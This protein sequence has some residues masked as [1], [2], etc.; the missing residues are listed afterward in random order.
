MTAIDHDNPYPSARAPVFGRSAVAT[1][2][3]LAS[4]AGMA[5]LMRGGNA[6]DAIVASAMALTVVEP[7]GNGI[8][9]DAFAIV[10]D[11]ER[12]HGLNSS[13]RAPAAWTPERFAGRT[14]MPVH[15]WESVSVPGAVASWAALSRRFGRLSLAEVAA[16][17]IRFAREG[18]AVT[19]I[20]ARLWARAGEQ[21]GAQP[22]FAECF[23]PG[24][25]APR[26]GELFRCEAQARTLEDI[27][28]TGGESFYR[29]DLARAMANDARRHGAAMTLEDLAEH[30]ADWVDTLSMPYAGAVLHELPPNGQGIATLIGLGLLDALDLGAANAYAHGVDDPHTVHLAIEATKLAMV[31]LHRYVGDPDTMD[32]GARQLLDPG[33]LASRARLID[34]ARAGDP[35][36]GTPGP[37]GTVCLAAGDS[38]GMMVSFIQSNYMGFGSGVVVPG[39]GI[40]LQNRGCGFT[41]EPGHP[42]RVG[43]RKRPFHT[44]IPGFA[45]NPDGTPLMAFGLMGGPMQAQGHL[46]LALR[47][48][49]HRQGPQVAADAPRWRVLSGLRV[50]VEPGMAASLT[51]ALK[52]LGHEIVVEPPDN[53]F[54]FGGAQIVRRTEHGYVAGSDP[55]K[56]GQALAW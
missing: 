19:P 43:P 34:P 51:D 16:P 42:N 6:V 23:L 1:S 25:R 26:A 31:D 20:I 28:A 2:Q 18:F 45:M 32:V 3:S 27:A 54:A 52:A 5:M 12:L 14:Q 29:G 10:W 50:S 24:G 30:S 46:Q 8:G 44:I 49:A 35:G 39:T 53:L 22:G 13:G 55:R 7:S 48:L 41:L 9:S 47:M 15:G 21:L 36:H 33:Y 17:A 38:D 37:A 56:D 40:S 11:G 4:Q